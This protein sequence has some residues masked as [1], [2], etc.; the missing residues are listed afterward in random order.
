METHFIFFVITS[1][2]FTSIVLASHTHRHNSEQHPPKSTIYILKPSITT[3]R[4]A[5]SQPYHPPTSLLISLTIPKTLCIDLIFGPGRQLFV[6]G[7]RDERSVCRVAHVISESSHHNIILPTMLRD[8]AAKTHTHTLHG[9]DGA[10]RQ[11]ERCFKPD[12]QHNIFIQRTI[13]YKL[14]V[15]FEGGFDYFYYK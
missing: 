15:R 8:S 9:M 11:C 10:Q 5:A 7:R 13:R 12:T 3:P 14:R 1:H 6:A 2:A 4:W